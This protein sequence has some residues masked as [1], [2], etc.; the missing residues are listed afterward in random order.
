MGRR[1]Y[2]GQ[3]ITPNG[4]EILHDGALAV[5]L[6]TNK[7]YIHD[8]VTPGGLLL[9]GLKSAPANAEG[10]SGD[11]IGD[12][13]IDEFTGNAY[14]PIRS[15][16]CKQTYAGEVIYSGINGTSGGAAS[17]VLRVAAGSQAN[18]GNV[19][20][21]WIMYGS[22]ITGNAT[23]TSIQRGPGSPSGS[24]AWELTINQAVDLRTAT[25]I[26][27]QGRP[28]IWLRSAIWDDWGTT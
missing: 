27:I 28:A 9:D 6:D 13:A 1:V 15:Y 2:K 8:G 16:Y 4:T 26:T 25:N 14:T 10:R 12:E 3:Y 21:G 5:D 17:A 7:L 23:I 24:N 11:T 19:R 22:P 20:V 18:M